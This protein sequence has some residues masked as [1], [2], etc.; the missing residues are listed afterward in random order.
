MVTLDKIITSNTKKNKVHGDEATKQYQNA[1]INS[2]HKH[3]EETTM[4]HHQNSNLAPFENNK[5]ITPD[6]FDPT[7]LPA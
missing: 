1:D 3:H 5:D 4:Y 6:L 2:S 7:F